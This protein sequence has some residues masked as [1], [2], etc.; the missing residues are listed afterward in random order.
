MK[1][2]KTITKKLV[3]VADDF[4]MTEEINRGIL[5]AYQEGIV[6]EIS[7]MLGAS[8]TSHALELIKR[9]N[10]ENIGLHLLLK[11]GD[12]GNALKVGQY[13]K[14][15]MDLTEDEITELALKEFETFDK[16]VGHKPTHICPQQGIHG[17]LKLLEIVLDYANENHIPVRIPRTA[18]GTNPEVTESENYAAEVLLR[19]EGVKSTDHLY[20]YILGSDAE[21]IKSNF[22]N[23]LNKV[24]AG[25]SAEIF[26]HPGY[27]DSE[28][29]KLTSLCYER[30]RDLAICIDKEFKDNIEK[31]GFQIVNYKSL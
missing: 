3:I 20:A 22:L 17:N 6:T 23:D 28:L 27:F 2:E 24:G 8:G 26:F 25:Q 15:F 11:V 21:Q 4:G 14:I 12:N 5:R 30:S 13:R 31:L 29:L 16:L 7:L 10:L 1:K 19:R 18:L 9:H